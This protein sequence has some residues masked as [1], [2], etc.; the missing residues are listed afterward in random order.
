[1]ELTQGNLTK[2]LQSMCVNEES[3][4]LNLYLNAKLFLSF[5]LDKLIST[6][7]KMLGLGLG[8]K[9]RRLYFYTTCSFLYILYWQSR[10]G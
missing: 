3:W 1:M 10:S 4:T 5:T 6:R 9:V 2:G 8:L 7:Q